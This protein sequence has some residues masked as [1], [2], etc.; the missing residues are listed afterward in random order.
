MNLHFAPHGLNFHLP[1]FAIH[2]ARP[3]RVATTTAPLAGWMERLA[4]WAERQPQ[5]HHAGS[6]ERFR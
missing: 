4:A 5:Y 2:P 6:W 1:R 3:V